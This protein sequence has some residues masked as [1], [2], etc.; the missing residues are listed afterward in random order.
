MSVCIKTMARYQGIERALGAALYERVR[1]AR[2]LVVG[3]GGIGCEL[4]KNLVMTSFLNHIEVIDL[5]TIDVSN[6]NRQFLFQRQHVSKSKAHVARETALQFE[7]NANIV[8]H[9]ASIFE[10]RFDVEFFK[11]FDVVIGAPSR[12]LQLARLLT[13]MQARLTTYPHGGTSTACA[14]LRTFL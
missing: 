1:S 9:H 2:V 11:S 8:S 14:W 7:P 10:S 6:L 4:L 12:C 3:A 5:D 13:A